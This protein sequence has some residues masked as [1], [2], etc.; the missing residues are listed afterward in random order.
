MA[1][2]V[3]DRVAEQRKEIVDRVIADMDKGGFEWIKPWKDVGFPHNPVSGT[4]YSGRN[5]T[6][7]AIMAIIRGYD[8]PRW[9]TFKQAKDAGWKMHKGAKSVVVEKWK[10]LPVKDKDNDDS[11]DK[12]NSQKEPKK[13]LIPRCVGYW[14]VF[15][16]SE[17]DGVPPLPKM[18][19]N[20]DEEISL[21]ADEVIA[22]SRCPIEE[23]AINN[24]AAYYPA[25]DRI[26]MPA[27]E[28]FT[29]NEAFLTTM[30]HE[31]GHSTGHPSAIGRSQ[32]TK[33]E[34]AE[35]AY[36]EL[37]AEMSSMFSA[38]DLGLSGDIDPESEHYQ[39]HVAY[40]QNWRQ[41]LSQEPNLLF[42]ASAAAEK[43]SDF[44][45][46]RYEQHVGHEAPGRAYLKELDSQ[47]PD[48]A[49]GEYR[50]GGTEKAKAEQPDKEPSGL[51]A[52]TAEA[53]EASDALRGDDGDAPGFDPR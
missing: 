10:M 15:N 8:D 7:L 44:V 41:A 14:S 42:K 53:R 26:V 12:D 43:A 19:R 30:L 9:V 16:A 22:S 29:S 1:S 47:I 38:A 39:S 35:Y 51:A 18:E 3:P 50:D 40:L 5:R 46:D 52:K 2:N 32:S 23:R 49:C 48:K 25:A 33:F 6:H 28:S 31:M 24:I 45:I 36:E 37:I 4:T 34:S 11:N 20:S 21:L 27:R 13:S 17:F